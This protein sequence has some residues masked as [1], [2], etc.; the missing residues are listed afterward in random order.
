MST[1]QFYD[2]ADFPW[3]PKLEAATDAIRQEMLALDPDEDF[4]VWPRPD[5]VKEAWEI[6]PLIVPGTKPNP[7]WATCPNTMKA[8]QKVNGVKM[9]VFSKLRAGAEILP[10]TGYTKAVLKAHLP[11][12][13]PAQSS[14]DDCAIQVIETKRTWSEGKVLLFDDKMPHQ[15]YNRTNTDRVLLI[16]EVLRPWKHRTSALGFIRQRTFTPRDYIH[17]Y[18]LIAREAKWTWP[19]QTPA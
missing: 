9:A 14:V 17:H 10:H 13:I 19:D 4:G 2:N 12:V 7:G 15:A 6:H 8:L 3:I 5:M 1:I 18:Q 16:F 11:L